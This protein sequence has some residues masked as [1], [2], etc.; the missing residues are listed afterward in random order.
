VTSQWL[1]TDRM[2]LEAADGRHL[3]VEPLAALVRHARLGKADLHN[4][5]RVEEDLGD[6]CRPPGA[7]FAQDALAKVEETGPDDADW[8]ERESGGSRALVQSEGKDRRFC[9]EL[10][11]Q[12]PRLVTKTVL[13]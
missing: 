11:S 8:V 3:E 2:P 5:S 12:A 6:G 13:G 7:N 10:D 9:R 1:S 4:A